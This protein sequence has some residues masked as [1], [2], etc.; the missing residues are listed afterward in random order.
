MAI[1]EVNLPLGNS[2]FDFK[3]K[4]PVSHQGLD[5]KPWRVIWISKKSPHEDACLQVSI[6]LVALL[7]CLSESE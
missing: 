5:L 1:L 7:V 6:C 4:P 3:D 2:E